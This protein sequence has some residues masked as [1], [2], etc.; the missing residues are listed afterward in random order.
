MRQLKDAAQSLTVGSAWDPSTRVSPLIHKPNEALQRGLTELEEGESWLLKPIALEENLWTP[1]IKLG[2]RQNSFMHQTELFGPVLGLMRAENLPHAI[3]LANDTIY[4]LTS[5]LHSLDPREHI[6]WKKKIVAGNLY[7]NR[8]IVGAVVGRQPFGGC[9]ASSFGPGAKAGGPNYL[10]QLV[11]LQEAEL[12]EEKR[13]LPQSIIPLMLTLNLSPEEKIVWRKSVESYAY[14]SKKY[15]TKTDSYLI[16]GQQNLFYLVPKKRVLIRYCDESYLDLLRVISAC[17]ICN[18]PYT[19]SSVKPLDIEAIVEDDTT[20]LQR[21]DG[22][23]IRCFSK[24]EALQQRAVETDTYLMAQPLFASGK[25]E[26]LH[27]LR[28]ISLSFDYHRYGYIENANDESKSQLL[29]T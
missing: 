1:G 27:Y 28:E 23:P 7:I 13:A 12:P 4:G 14:W 22:T 20:F 9:K 21:V 5:G 15:Q 10:R 3:E 24:S 6:L 11:L 8:N 16:T 29:A 18:T 19:L 25:V 17:I 26:L 2:V